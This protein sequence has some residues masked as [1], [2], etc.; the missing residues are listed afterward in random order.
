M[1]KFNFRGKKNCQRRST[2]EMAGYSSWRSLNAINTKRKER[3]EKAQRKCR[4]AYRPL[5]K[6]SFL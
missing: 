6:I 2:S 4:S 5:E 1:Q 3:K